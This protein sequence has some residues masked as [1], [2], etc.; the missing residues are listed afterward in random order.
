ML[1]FG[2]EYEL[3][4]G[5]RRCPG[6]AGQPEQV[7]GEVG[8]LI[9]PRQVQRNS[10]DQAVDERPVGRWRPATEVSTTTLEKKT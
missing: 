6:P 2:G 1:H 10:A 8:I 3:A 7:V 5:E 9:P 4:F